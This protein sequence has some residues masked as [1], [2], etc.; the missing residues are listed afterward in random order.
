MPATSRA[1]TVKNSFTQMILSVSKD[2]Q[3][4]IHK[5]GAS[6][7]ANREE[8]ANLLRYAR[9]KNGSIKKINSLQVA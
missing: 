5:D 8:A 7:D 2:G 4:I 3:P 9:A 6:Y 1:Y